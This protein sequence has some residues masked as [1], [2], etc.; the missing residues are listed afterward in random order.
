MMYTFSVQSVVRGY[1]EY[2][3]ICDIAIDGLPCKREPGNP[4]DQSAV[5][6]LRYKCRRWT[7]SLTHFNGLLYIY[8]LCVVTGL[9][10]YS[11]DLPQGGKA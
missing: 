1:H 9:Q 10:K 2:K 11:E 4:H 5:N 3:D 8:M 6:K 7:Y